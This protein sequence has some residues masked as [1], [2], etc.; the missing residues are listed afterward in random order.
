MVPQSGSD[1]VSSPRA[2]HA[3][4]LREHIDGT[5][6]VLQCPLGAD[7]IKAVVREWHRVSIGDLE[8]DA[9][10][11]VPRSRFIDQ[12]R[13]RIDSNDSAGRNNSARERAHVIT[14]TT[15]DI[16]KPLTD[17]WLKE[18]L[19]RGFFHRHLGCHALNVGRE[20]SRPSSSHLPDAGSQRIC[21][22]G[23]RPRFSARQST[24][25]SGHDPLPVSRPNDGA[26]ARVASQFGA[27]RDCMFGPAIDEVRRAVG[28][29]DE[30]AH[31]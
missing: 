26:G 9:R 30:P 28:G 1:A 27:Y 10:S 14:D 12:R 5:F 18:I 4:H 24:A 29:V 15:T 11:R 25:I 21:S 22:A 16:Q 13:T 8:L 7:G 19:H 6:H 23:H 3:G 31:A 17:P 2:G 20:V